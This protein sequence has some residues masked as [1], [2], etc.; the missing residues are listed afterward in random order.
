VELHASLPQLFFS[1]PNPRNFRMGANDGWNGT[2]IHQAPTANQWLSE[3]HAIFP[4]FSDVVA[5][6]RHPDDARPRLSIH[7]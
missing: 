6:V 5:T 7:V 3:G 2:A 1:V 4:A